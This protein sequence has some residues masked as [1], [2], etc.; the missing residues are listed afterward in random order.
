MVSISFVFSGI[1]FCGFGRTSTP[2]TAPSFLHHLA[3]SVLATARAWVRFLDAAAALRGADLRALRGR[4]ERAAF[5]LNLY[6]HLLFLFL[7]LR[8][9][10]SF[11]F[12]SPLSLCTPFNLHVSPRADFVFSSRLASVPMASTTDQPVEKRW[13]A[14]PGTTSWCSTP[15]SCSV[16]PRARRRGPSTSSARGGSISRRNTKAFASLT[17]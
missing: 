3:K 15:R 7:P 4:E 14:R 2:P 1:L 10:S 5:F 16:R 8:G 13:P 9:V 11:C 17:S 12:P 6:V